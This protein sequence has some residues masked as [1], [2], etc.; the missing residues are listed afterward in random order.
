MVRTI[1][2]IQRRKMDKQKLPE[3][4]FW[5]NVYD[6]ARINLMKNGIKTV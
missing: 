2:E 5:W 6:P 1:M 3:K 4:R